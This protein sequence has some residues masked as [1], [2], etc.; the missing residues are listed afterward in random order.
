MFLVLLAA[1]LKLKIW[2]LN[3]SVIR[4]FIFANQH[5]TL[6]LG[7]F[8]FGSIANISVIISL[9]FF[10]FFSFSQDLNTPTQQDSHP[11]CLQGLK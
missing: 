11:A 1:F 4:S 3:G 7:F 6:S 9:L 10:H 8:F 5:V 2:L